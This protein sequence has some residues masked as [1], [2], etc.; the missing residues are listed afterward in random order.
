MVY[1]TEK[2]HQKFCGNNNN[3]NN[4]NIDDTTVSCINGVK[5]EANTISYHGTVEC[6]V[7][8]RLTIGFNEQNKKLAKCKAL[9]DTFLSHLLLTVR[10]EMWLKKCNVLQWG[11]EKKQVF[12]FS[13]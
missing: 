12:L 13:F 9:L 1:F 4:N 5:E 7:A 8:M 3:N 2:N 6:Y 10:Q 11:S